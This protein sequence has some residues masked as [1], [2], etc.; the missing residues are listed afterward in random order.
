[1]SGPIVRSGPTDRY[2]S[3][4]AR[5]FGAKPKKHAAPKAT[6]KKVVAKKKKKSG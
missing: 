4:W 5:A 3:N 2:S 1:M 6:K